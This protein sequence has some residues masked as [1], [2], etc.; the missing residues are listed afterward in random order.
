VRRRVPARPQYGLPTA[1]DR[2]HRSFSLAWDVVR[3]GCGQILRFGADVPRACRIQHLRSPQLA[4]LTQQYD[5][6]EK[7]VVVEKA[8]WEQTQTAV[9]PLQYNTRAQ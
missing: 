8:I 3:R 2:F 5:L 6:K 7:M 1:L 4:P 9:R